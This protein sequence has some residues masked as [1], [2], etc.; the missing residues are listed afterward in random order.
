LLLLVAAILAVGAVTRCCAW[1]IKQAAGNHII[2]QG[3][4]STFRDW[5][6]ER[7]T[8]S[9]QVAEMTLTHTIP[10][11]VQAAY[12]RYDLFEK[13]RGL[14]GARSQFC[15]NPGTTGEVVPIWARR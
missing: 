15:A 2:T 5:A 4:R 13:R 11:A 8:F 9:R 3:L 7:T 1:L 6:A 10:N 14:M 12:R